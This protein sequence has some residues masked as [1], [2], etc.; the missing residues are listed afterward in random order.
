MKWM[1]FHETRIYLKTVNC[2]DN[3]QEA[4][5]T[6]TDAM[7]A[8]FTPMRFYSR[9]YPYMGSKAA[10]VHIALERTRQVRLCSPHYVH[11][12]SLYPVCPCSPHVVR[13]CSLHFCVSARCTL[14]V[15]VCPPCQA[16][17]WHASSS[18]DRRLLC[19]DPLWRCSG[20]APAQDRAWHGLALVE[21]RA[22]TC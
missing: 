4:L 9:Y 10:M 20:A 17:S 21:A 8:Y 7:R 18:S 6:T 13:P 1:L 11:L 16:C 14:R 3:V 19:G 22:C 5:A 15:C 2:L 12:W